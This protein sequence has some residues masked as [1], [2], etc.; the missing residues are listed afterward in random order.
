MRF[1]LIK[2]EPALAGSANQPDDIYRDFVFR[3]FADV[4][5]VDRDGY[6]DLPDFGASTLA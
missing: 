4:L 3:R 6:L 1:W 2:T 5:A